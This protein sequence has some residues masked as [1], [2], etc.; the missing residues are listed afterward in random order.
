M[1]SQFNEDLLVVF[2]NKYK[3]ILKV[4]NIYNFTITVLRFFFFVVY[5]I[6]PINLYSLRLIRSLF[7]QSIQ[8]VTIELEIF[9]TSQE[10]Y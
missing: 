6:F 1:C 3:Q 5:V 4:K 10:F 9:M 7:F 8:D 2:Q